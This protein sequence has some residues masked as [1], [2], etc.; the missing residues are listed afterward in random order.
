MGLSTI[1][2]GPDKSAGSVLNAA[3][4]STFDRLRTWDF[5]VKGQDERSLRGAF[6]ELDRLRSI[7]QLSDAIVEKTAYLY[8]RAQERGLVRGR[9]IRAMLG[10]PSIL[11]RERDGCFRHP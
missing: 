11:C 3:M 1:I 6:V 5:R 7:I 4:H 9:T 10:Q 2:G 8:R